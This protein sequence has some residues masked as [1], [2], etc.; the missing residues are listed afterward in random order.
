MS[1]EQELCTSTLYKDNKDWSDIV[2]IYPSEDEDRAVKIAVTEDF[3]DAFAY[4]RAILKKKEFSNR[5]L[6]LLEDCIRLNP[7]NYTVWQYRRETLKALNSDLKKEIKY[8]DTI[9]EET[10]KNY[11]VWHHR[12]LIVEQIGASML[13]YELD[14]T[15]DILNDENKNYHA[16]QHRQ[17]VVRT[18]KSP[19]DREL[20]FA[21]RLLLED[22]RNNSAYN[23]RYFLLTLYKKTEDRET[24]DS[25]ISLAKK[26]I[27]GMPNNESVWNYLAGLLLENGIS[28]NQ[29]IVNFVEDL[30]ERTEGQE[31]S[32]MMVS[33]IADIMLE[34]IEKRV[35]CEQSAERAKKLYNELIEL[36]PVR[37]NYWKHQIHIVDFLVDQCDK[38]VWSWI[39]E[40]LFEM[41]RILR[42]VYPNGD[43]LI[44][45]A[46]SDYVSR[47]LDSAWPER[48]YDRHEMLKVLG[49]V[50]PPVETNTEINQLG[51]LT[52]AINALA[53]PKVKAAPQENEE[54][55]CDVES[56][57]IDRF[58][59]EIKRVEK[60]N[61]IDTVGNIIMFTRFENDGDITKLKNEVA[62]LLRMHN[63]MTTAATSQTLLPITDLR[64]F[65]VNLYT[66]NSC[67]VSTS[68]LVIYPPY[69]QMR[70]W[71]ISRNASQYLQVFR[72]ITLHAFHLASTTVSKIPMKEEIKGTSTSS[73][74]D[75]ELFHPR[76]AL[77]I[78]KR[79]K[80]C[81]LVNS[82]ATSDEGVTYETN[83]LA[84]ATA[85]KSKWSL[86]PYQRAAFPCTPSES[87]SRPATCLTQFVMD[88]RC[89][90]LDLERKGAASKLRT[91]V[92]G[93]YLVSHLLIAKHGRIYLHTVDIAP[94]RVNKNLALH[95]SKMTPIRPPA[96]KPN[97]AQFKHVME[98]LKLKKPEIDM[99]KGKNFN[100]EN[101]KAFRKLRMG[102]ARE[103][104]LRLMRHIPLYA[105][106]TF[107]FHPQVMK[108]FEPLATLITKKTLDDA[109]VENCAATIMK[110]R[111]KRDQMVPFCSPKADI[112]TTLV[113]N[114]SDASEQAR[115]AI[116]EFAR[117]LSLYRKNSEKHEKIYRDYDE[118]LGVSKM[119]NLDVEDIIPNDTNIE[120]FP[121]LFLK[122]DS[123]TLRRMLSDENLEDGE[124]VS[125]KR[126]KL[127]A[128]NKSQEPR[129]W[130]PI[131]ID[132]MELICNNVEEHVKKTRRDFAARENF[133]DD[134]VLY[135][136]LNA[137]QPE[138]AMA[139]E[140]AKHERGGSGTPPRT[141]TNNRY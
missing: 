6:I 130:I 15:G 116:V 107:V 39:M 126:V 134:V 79:L 102:E 31:R 84:W 128:L 25:E 9:I 2:P 97:T 61:K 137:S 122:T 66:G 72:S 129:E 118:A 35:N 67:N 12:R 109:D 46:V 101:F 91:N 69:P 59:D 89:V 11:Q 117:L 115:I 63:E 65:I 60:P 48:G 124:V 4:F 81:G 132:V 71:V 68:P 108:N 94:R 26:F 96:I 133:G 100:E 29:N 5:V 45:F 20:S 114:M 53:D 104:M 49:N 47:M 78:L 55:T 56:S 93:K 83:R 40:G 22:P 82:R 44:R 120:T 3:I 34:N 98:Q 18:F 112:E 125:P 121:C 57:E 30:Y 62:N 87:S 41:H 140:R 131:E 1:D 16:W 54:A 58:I 51:G 85:P 13:D 50:E 103:K 113:K 36:D 99:I 127:F 37:V 141:A 21:L 42:D 138:A 74:Y 17:W 27:E 14:F 106:D 32:P 33:F 90:L 119:L 19:L 52:M 8:L 123:T 76:A 80:I 86:F 92:G 70:T 139:D 23:Y 43:P 136:N 77:N 38:P 73:N 7:A 64:L 105:K 111:Q 110:V 10:P 24:I 95:L 75:V 28:S 135:P 88:G